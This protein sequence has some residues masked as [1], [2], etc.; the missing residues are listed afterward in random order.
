MP[1]EATRRALIFQDLAAR[2]LVKALQSRP[3]NM[4]ADAQA[5]RLMALRLHRDPLRGRR[6]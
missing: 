5:W 3:Q 4:R 6:I 1:N 2:A